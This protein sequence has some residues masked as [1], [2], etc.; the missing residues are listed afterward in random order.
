MFLIA[1]VVCI[2]AF[3]DALLSCLFSDTGQYRGIYGKLA[4]VS[5]AISPLI[6]KFW[7]SIPA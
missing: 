5:L 2:L 7:L 1:Y 6:I 4:Y 3:T